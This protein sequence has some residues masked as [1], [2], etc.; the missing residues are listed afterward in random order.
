LPLQGFDKGKVR[1]TD[2][3]DDRYERPEIFLP[4]LPICPKASP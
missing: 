1:Q 2:I 3:S 4:Q